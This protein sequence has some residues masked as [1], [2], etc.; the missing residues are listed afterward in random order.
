[1]GFWHVYFGIY[2]G[3]GSVTTYVESAGCVVLEFRGRV[4]TQEFN[5]RT[6]VIERKQ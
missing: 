3:G 2:G 1:M 5:G 4:A 6:A